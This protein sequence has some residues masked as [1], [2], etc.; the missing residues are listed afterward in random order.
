M[1][2]ADRDQMLIDALER[3]REYVAHVAEAWHERSPAVAE[4]AKNDLA[5]VDAVLA[6]VGCRQQSRVPT[7][8]EVETEARRLRCQAWSPRPDSDWDQPDR[9]HDDNK[10]E[11]R[12][13][14][15]AKLSREDEARGFIWRAARMYV[16]GQE[17]DHV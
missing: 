11:W 7:D 9:I 5:A 13:L 2:P 10:D 14:A 17:S 6:Q 12:R 8:E 1:S 3:A 16:E 4:A 15:R